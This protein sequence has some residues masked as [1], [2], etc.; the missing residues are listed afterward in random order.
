MIALESNLP[1][2]QNIEDIAGGTKSTVAL[3]LFTPFFTAV[4][5]LT[6]IGQA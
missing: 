6:T 4:I 1:T 2:S 3:L 5:T